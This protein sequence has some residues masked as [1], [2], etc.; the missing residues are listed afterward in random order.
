MKAVFACW[1]KANISLFHF[2]CFIF[3]DQMVALSL[4]SHHLIA[5]VTHQLLWSL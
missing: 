5:M 2:L 4:G 3:L 1:F